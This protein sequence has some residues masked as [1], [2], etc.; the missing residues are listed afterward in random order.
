[1][2][3]KTSKAYYSEDEAA[4]KLGVSVDEL[5]SLVRNHI[6]TGEEMPAVEVFQPSDLVLLRILAQHQ[7]RLVAQ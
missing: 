5:R 2:V 3:N 4:R 7:Y 6:S 1:M